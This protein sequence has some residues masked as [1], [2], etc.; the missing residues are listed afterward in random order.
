MLQSSRG[1]KSPC[2]MLWNIHLEPQQCITLD[3]NFNHK[4][5]KKGQDCHWCNQRLYNKKKHR[6]RRKGMISNSCCLGAIVVTTTSKDNR[7]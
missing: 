5:K 3:T 2:K 7:T 4:I 6:P 1:K